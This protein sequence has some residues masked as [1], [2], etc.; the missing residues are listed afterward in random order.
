VSLPILRRAAI[1]R[2]DFRNDEGNKQMTIY[3]GC[4]QSAFGQPE[5]DIMCRALDIIFG[6]LAEHGYSNFSRDIIAA[7][8][9]ACARAGERDPGRMAAWTLGAPIEPANATYH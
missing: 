2:C 3:R 9:I 6:E 4:S 7:R 1:E 5:I 8:V